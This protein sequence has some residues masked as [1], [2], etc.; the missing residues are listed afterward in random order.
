MTPDSIFS[1]KGV[2]MQNTTTFQSEWQLMCQQL[3]DQLKDTS[4]MRW[5]SRVVPELTSDNKLNVWAPSACICELV[6]MRYSEAI[7]A[8]WQGK[9]P[10]SSIY[11]GIKKVENAPTP[12]VT[13]QPIMLNKPVITTK[14]ATAAKITL[15]EEDIYT[16]FLDKTHTFDSFV[17]GPSNE[18]AY[19]AAKQ[20]A[21]DDNV[22]FNPLYL[23]A[24]VGLGKTHLMHAIAWRIKEQH[25]EK[26]VLY[27]SSEQFLQR[28]LKSLQAKDMN[29]FKELFRNVDVLLVDD[30][31]FI[32][33]KQR[34]QE[35]F[36]HT[37]NN[38][39]ARGKK[40]ILS[41]DSAPMELHGIEERL[42]TRIAQGLVV[43]IQ[44]ASYE[45]RLGI[46]NE[47]LK[48]LG[49][50]LDKDV[51]SFLAKNIT[52]NVRELEGALKR[53]VAHRQLLGGEITLD[54]T[55]Q[56]LKDI[57]HTMERQVRA[58]EIQQM[59]ADYYRLPLKDLR[60]TRRDRSIARPRQMAMYLTK[61]MT[62]MALPD[63]AKF[64]E[65]DHTTIMHAVKTIENL[66]TR[67]K[68]LAQDKEIIMTQLKTIK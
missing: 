65:R 33:G 4:V 6:Q 43:N 61:I 64:Y 3:S 30:I 46:L 45:L 24:G 22:A 34:T 29:N 40:I 60:S 2:K 49:A 25:P 28:F 31:Q 18:F 50:D 57:L 47:K 11:I 5:M 63:I 67:D 8:W 66:L 42:Q 21:D 38:L 23:Q 68:Q 15:P 37:F 51:L 10:D 53:L 16:Q 56:I 20:I 35:E 14:E 19:V 58:P 52:S 59:V 54:S 26:T 27:L 9:N 12:A 32:V 1:M 48:R 44:P 7:R 17:V 62:P 39:I 13:P 41:S 36:F 55:K